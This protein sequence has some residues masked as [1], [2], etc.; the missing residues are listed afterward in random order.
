[1]D[2]AL[3]TPHKPGRS[4]NAEQIKLIKS[5]ICKG[6]TDDE[7][8][9]FLY[10]CNRTGLDPLARQAFAVKRWDSSQ[11][12]EVMSI[13]TSIDGFR[14]IA[15]RSGEYEGQTKAEWC[16]SDAKWLEVWLDNVPPLAAKVGVY[17]K[18]FR[19]PL[20]ATARYHAYVQMNKQGKPTQ[21]WLKMPDVMIAKCAEALALRKAFPHELS[22]LYTEDEMVGQVEDKTPP[23]NK[24][25]KPDINYIHALARNI[26]DFTNND[27]DAAKQIL[28]DLTGK[29]ST[30]ELSQ[31]DAMAA[32]MAFE[33]KY[34]QAGTG[35]NED[36]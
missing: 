22:G 5:T 25:A 31:T 23:E 14:L 2:S 16:G 27:T 11:N 8:K 12:K 1:M 24:E 36:V 7:L 15:E 33:K 35:E 17:R 30:K 18:N 32:Q 3:Q 19:E 34:L 26:L 6:A 29:T 13:Q 10:T 21:N 20:Y 28:Q 9:L 4:L